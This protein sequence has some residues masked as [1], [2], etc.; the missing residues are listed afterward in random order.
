MRYILDSEG[1]VHEASL[2]A[3]IMCDLGNCTEYTGKVPSGYTTIEEWFIGEASQINAWKVVEGDLVFDE[4]KAADL[5]RLLEEQAALNRHVTHKELEARLSNFTVEASNQAELDGILPI[6]SESGDVIVLLDSSSY[7]MERITIECREE[8]DDLKLYISTSNML[9]NEAKSGHKDGITYLVDEDKAITLIGSTDDFSLNLSGSATNT[10]PIFILKAGETYYIGDTSGVTLNLYTN[11]GTDRV[12][13]YTGTGGTSITPTEDVL[14]T[15]AEINYT[16]SINEEVK[17]MIS[18][19]ESLEYEP[20]EYKIVPI[21]L[22]RHITE[23]DSIID[24]E[25]QIIML[26]GDAINIFE[27][28]STFYERTTMYLNK[29]ASLDI[30]YKKSGFDTVTKRGK[31]TVTLRNTADGYG[32][33][34]NFTIEDLEGGEIYTLKTS[35]GKDQSEQYKIDLTDYTGSV[36][37][38]IEEGQTIVEHNSTISFLDNIYIRTYSPRTYIELVGCSNRLTCEYMVESEFSVYCTRVEKDASIQML[39]DKISLEVKRASE[40]EGELAGQINIEAG[41]IEQIVTSVGTDGEVTAGSIIMAINEDKESEIKISADKVDIEGMT[42]PT[43]SNKD[44]TNYISSVYEIEDST[45]LAYRSQQHRFLNDYDELMFRIVGSALELY[46]QM[47]MI[48]TDCPWIQIGGTEATQTLNL[49]GRVLV[50]GEEIGTGGGGGGGSDEP[51]SPNAASKLAQ[52]QVTLSA[53]GWVENTQSVSAKGV[54]A[55]N[56]VWT[57]PVPSEQYLYTNYNIIC[58]AQAGGILTFSCETVPEEDLTVNVVVGESTLASSLTQVAATLTLADWV[59]NKQTI[60][61][62][63][64][65]IETIVWVSPNPTSNTEYTR[66]EILC[67]EQNQGTLTFSCTD[68]PMEDVA[69]NIILAN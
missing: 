27:M 61:I 1:Y 7:P 19:K 69:I 55:S 66:C 10:E 16:G 48:G 2:G 54:T 4:D 53:S 3:A 8:I 63:D 17:L 6:S 38:I 64:V 21:D 34:F 29:N 9:P 36:D 47:I 12:L 28:P 20:C 62:E 33:I 41:K 59:E 57:A 13:F 49:C 26:D 32:S 37:I 14:V 30:D 46:G 15:H 51:E 42:F 25:D 65:S 40:M 52:T 35:D 67:V 45:C 43:I 56:V 39:D 24:I 44:G 58:T 11:D 18:A 50:N 60:A 68:V 23:T 31:G 5:E 22:N